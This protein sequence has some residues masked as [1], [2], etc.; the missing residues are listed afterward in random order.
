MVALHRILCPLDL[1]D[2]SGRALGYALMLSKWYRA[3]VT[4]LEVVWLGVPSVVPN[5]APRFLS[6]AHLSEF[7]SA[8]RQFVEDHSAGHEQ[9]TTALRHGP[10]VPQILLE[11]ESLPADLIVMGTHG[12]SGFERLILG[13]ITEKVLRKARCPVLTVPPAT[14]DAPAGP[15]PFTSIVCA[16]DFSPAS[17]KALDYALALAQESGKRLT[18][19][20]VFDWPVDRPVPTGLEPGT[21]T[22]RQ[23]QDSARQELR[24]AVPEDARL[25]CEIKEITAIGRPHEEILRVADESNA[26]L[27]VLGV[28]SRR[29]LEF[30]FFGSTTNQV[31]RH[32]ACPVLTIRP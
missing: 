19:V 3:P 23:Y 28:H 13:S 7:S 8:L 26:D 4:A 27:I 21:P 32:S 24:A 14:P 15:Q 16:V 17:L 30:G 12:I 29:T 1:S 20:H 2:T 5:T 6:K 9:V 25:W 22:A 11:A 18:L 10:V 31:V